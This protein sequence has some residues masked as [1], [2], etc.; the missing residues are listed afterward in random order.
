VSHGECLELF[1]Q[2]YKPDFTWDY[3]SLEEQA[4]IL[5][6]GRSNNEL[7]C[8]KLKAEFPELL[9]IKASLVKYVFE[10]QPGASNPPVVAKPKA[11]PAQGTKYVVPPTFARPDGKKVFLVFGRTGWLGGTLGELLT[12]AGDTFQYSKCRLHDRPGIE[13]EI[14]A[15]Q[16]THIMCAAGVTGRPNVD[17]CES[18]RVETLKTNVLGMLTLADICEARGIHLTNFATGCIFEYDDAHPLG[19]G[20]GFT[21]EEHAN[22]ADSFYSQTKGYV[23]EMLRSYNHVLTLR[24]RMPIGADL[25]WGRNFLY[26]ISHYAKVVNIPNSMTVLPEMMPIS[27]EMA[28]RRLVGIYNFTNPG[29]VSHGECM[30][31]YKKYYMPEKTWEFFSLE[32]QAKILAAGRSNNELDCSKL[33]AEFPE[34]LDIKA[35]LLKYVFEPA[36]KAKGIAIE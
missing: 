24:V 28:K 4:K 15:L 32:E 30:D 27:V 1:K 23:E 17:W 8:S 11:P 25:E 29:V 21:E 22:F 19:S 2:Y 6:S 31:M 34:L 12:E 33:K 14:E 5:A 9:D 3:F 26:K 13:A 18:N 35:S 16:P 7:D 20:I 36:A 10:V